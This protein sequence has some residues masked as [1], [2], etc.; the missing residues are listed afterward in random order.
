MFSKPRSSSQPRSNPLQITH[1]S[2]PNEVDFHG[3][4]NEDPEQINPIEKFTIEELQDTSLFHTPWGI[5]NK[6]TPFVAKPHDTNKSQK[7]EL[8]ILTFMCLIVSFGFIAVVFI[9]PSQ[10]PL[11]Y[12]VVT[13]SAALVTCL[14]VQVV[15]KVYYPSF[16][17]FVV[18]LT[19]FPFVGMYFRGGLNA[20][21]SLFIISFG[22]L[23]SATVIERGNIVSFICISALYIVSYITAIVVEN[24]FPPVTKHEPFSYGAVAVLTGFIMGLILQTS[25]QQLT[26]RAEQL[27]DLTSRLRA[28]KER[29]KQ[30]VRQTQRDYFAF[31]CH[32]I[33]TPLHT[34]TSI[35]EV[36]DNS[37]KL[38]HQKESILAAK[39]AAGIMRAML[40]DVLDWSRLDAGKMDL[41]RNEFNLPDNL[42][43]IVSLCSRTDPLVKVT[44]KVAADLPTVVVGDALRLTQVLM[45]LINNAVKFTSKCPDAEVQ[46]IVSPMED[47]CVGQPVMVRFEVLDNGVGIEPSRLESLFEPYVQE[48]VK[49]AKTHGGTGLGLS[50]CKKI[51]NLMKGNLSATSKGKSFGSSF[52]FTVPFEWKEIT[53]VVVPFDDEGLSSKNEGI[54]V[55]DDND[56]VR[57]T[58]AKQLTQLGFQPYTAATANEAIELFQK[59]QQEQIPV[60][61]ILTDYNLDA[62]FKGTDV[63]MAIRSSFVNGWK[64]VEYLNIIMVTGEERMVVNKQSWSPLLDEIL[65]KPVPRA[66][67]V[68]VLKSLNAKGTLRTGK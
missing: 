10:S 47:L 49:V 68:R 31:L 14:L 7:W 56:I 44:S 57:F 37:D 33:R 11:F 54:L 63:A 38:P 20:D 60:H 65:L 62:D 64:G 53:N 12:P 3:I 41:E 29:E 30:I 32:E 36:L 40:N 23:W 51:V 52:H 9:W 28:Q 15:F 55:V 1:D 17:L 27:I 45:N 59:L 42:S 22:G 58:T 4:A 18:S 25:M 21:R 26:K 66:E 48:N 2:T 50:I 34:L 13:M 43:Q 19:I 16:V 6:I 35:V 39:N 46:I 8:A 61:F 5:R 24:L 67:M